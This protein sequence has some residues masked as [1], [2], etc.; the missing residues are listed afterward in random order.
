MKF[1]ILVLIFFAYNSV[2]S[3][4]YTENHLKLADEL[5]DISEMNG[6]DVSSI[7]AEVLDYFKISP[8][9]KNYQEVKDAYI[10]SFKNDYLVQMREIYVSYYSE[11]DIRELLQFYKSD[12]GQKVLKNSGQLRNDIELSSELWTEKIYSKLESMV[13]EER[14]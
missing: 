2:F 4:E 13:D 3:V 11:D 10:D 12:I 7:A 1:I 14:K 6:V 9:I 8:D 5:I